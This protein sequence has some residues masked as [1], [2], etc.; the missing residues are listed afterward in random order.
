MPCTTAPSTACTDPGLDWPVRECL[1]AQLPLPSPSSSPPT[2]R[3][4]WHP[5]S[6]PPKPQEA[7]PRP[8]SPHPG[9]S[10]KAGGT[11]AFPQLRWPGTIATCP[12]PAGTGAPFPQTKDVAGPPVLLAPKEHP[13][14]KEHMT[15][16]M[17]PGQG[18]TTEQPFPQLLAGLEHEAQ[19]QQRACRGTMSGVGQGCSGSRVHLPTHG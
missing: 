19:H 12:D 3:K 8:P 10:Q 16:Q 15:Q 13:G 18:H 14:P 1:T 9:P 5:A 4:G 11:S 17:A 7:G 6:H 2:S